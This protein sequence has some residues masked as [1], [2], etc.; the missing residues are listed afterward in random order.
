M[1]TN[2]QLSQMK[3][4]KITKTKAKMITQTVNE[5]PSHFLVLVSALAYHCSFEYLRMDFL[6]YEELLATLW[7]YKYCT[8]SGKLL[9]CL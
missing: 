1:E 5:Q 9:D 6:C 2:L 7:V 3:L 4:E 8:F